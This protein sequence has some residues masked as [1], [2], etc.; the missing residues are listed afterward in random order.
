MA[1][2]DKRGW[3]SDASEADVRQ[4]SEWFDLRLPSR[5]QEFRGDE[6]LVPHQ[7]CSTCL[8]PAILCISS[9]GLP[10]VLVTAMVIEQDAART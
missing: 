6:F 2:H 9:Y 8:A 1:R 4:L 5:H 3:E 10:D 7:S